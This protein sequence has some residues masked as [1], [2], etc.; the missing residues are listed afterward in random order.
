MQTRT[1]KRYSDI[2]AA[3]F[4]FVLFKQETSANLSLARQENTPPLLDRTSE[5]DILDHSGLEVANRLT[6][7]LET[8]NSI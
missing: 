5:S 6:R 1:P 4:C 8:Q 3:L 2:S 7:F